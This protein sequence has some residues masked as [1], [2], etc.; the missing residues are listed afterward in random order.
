MKL[1]PSFMFVPFLLGVLLTVCCNI[2][3]CFAQEKV[4]RLPDS[5]ASF[6]ERAEKFMILS[7]LFNS[8]DTTTGRE[9]DYDS[10]KPCMDIFQRQMKKHG[11]KMDA[12]S[13]VIRLR[14]ARKITKAEVFQGNG[15]TDWLVKTVKTYDSKEQGKNIKIK[16]FFG[17][18]TPQ[19]LIGEG[20]DS[21]LREL[22]KDRI[23]V[24]L[25]PYDKTNKRLITNGKVYDL[26]GLEP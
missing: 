17:I 19:F 8:E 25:V 6:T 18:Y 2:E 14:L 16:F 5:V 13:L 26:G 11:F 15:L 12:G 23:G 9:V 24:F 21:A 1:S 3:H 22:K 10:A 20:L 4:E 7:N